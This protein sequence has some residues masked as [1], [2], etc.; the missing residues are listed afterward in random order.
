M[1][2]AQEVRRSTGPAGVSGS[3]PHSRHSALSVL[4]SF[5]TPPL[6]FAASLRRAT[7]GGGKAAA[8][9][10]GKDFFAHRRRNRPACS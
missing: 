7:E 6:R 1:E 5:I 3:A 2:R 9:S 4:I 10:P 8:V